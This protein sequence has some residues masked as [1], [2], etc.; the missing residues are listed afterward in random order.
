MNLTVRSLEHLFISK[1][2][3]KAL[4]Y[5]LLNPNES[6]HLRGAVRELNEEINAV[7]RELTRLEEMKIIDAEAKGNRKYFTLN[8]SH[9]FRSELMA[10]MHKTYG[11]GGEIVANAKKLGEVDFA[12]LTPA[13]TKHV[14]FGNHIVDMVIVGKVE[15]SA[16]EQ[17]VKKME[18]ELER[19]IHYTVFTNQEFQIRKRRKD[20]FILDLLFQ[21]LVMILG[22]KEELIQ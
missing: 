8:K 22:T 13:Y 20:Q 12:F 4:E 10:M 15:M 18:I 6:I 1:V 21:D 11:L 14:F 9:P 3:I 7:R 19:E 17:L 2:R 16:L 5:F